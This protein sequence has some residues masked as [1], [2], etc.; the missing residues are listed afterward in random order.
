MELACRHRNDTARR[1]VRQQERRYAD[2]Q[3]MPSQR[4]ICITLATETSEIYAKTALIDFA[5]NSRFMASSN[6]ALLILFQPFLLREH[7]QIRL[8]L[9]PRTAASSESANPIAQ[10]N[11]TIG[12]QDIY[13][14]SNHLSISK[15]CTSSP[16]LLLMHEHWL[17]EP[18][19]LMC[20]P[21]ADILQGFSK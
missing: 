14:T 19:P 12:Q 7:E 3:G 2:V 15:S 21:T 13:F 20:S 4:E 11:Q 16:Y 10:R 5:A 18:P 1:G 17:F 6:A 9:I 8:L